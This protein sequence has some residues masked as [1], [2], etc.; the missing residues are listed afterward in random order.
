MN[1]AERWQMYSRIQE[2]KSLNLKISQIARHVGVCRN[3]V[4]KYINMTPE[5]YHQDLE[6]RETRK[7]KLDDYRDKI[8]EWLKEY[9]D[10]ST[11]QVYDWL[12]EEHTEID[13]CE[14]TV[15]NLVNQ[16]RKEYAIPKI[17]YKREYEAIPDPPMGYQVQVDFG[18]KKLKDPD[19][20]LHKLWF[21]AFVLS[22]SRYKYVEW[23]DRPFTTADLI[24]MHEN[25]FRYYEGMPVEF[26][27]DQDHLILVSEN[28]GDLIYTY[29]FAA[30]RQQRDFKIHMCRKSDPESKGRIE[31]VVGYVKKNFAQHRVY[32]NLDKLNEQCLDWL[33][34]TGNGKMHNAVERHFKINPNIKLKLPPNPRKQHII[35]PYDTIIPGKQHITTTTKQTKTTIPQ[36]PVL[37]HKLYQHPNKN[38]TTGQSQN[39]CHTR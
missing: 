21:I 16:L 1:R 35:I 32:H 38:K 33:E 17:V 31:N 10:L 8:L 22:N 12:Q 34:R 27:Y 37:I 7:K 19:G 24:R 25:C 4:Y 28:H 26:V 9:P 15:G 18:E 39:Q 29:E 36:L 11:A 13:V 3:T 14:R 20:I 6:R 23:S 30:Y 5:E 2:L